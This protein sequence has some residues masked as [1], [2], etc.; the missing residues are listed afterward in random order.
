M[1]NL[2]PRTEFSDNVFTRDR[3]AWWGRMDVPG[4]NVVTDERMT[5]KTA[6]QRFLP[7]EIEKVELGYQ[8][9]E[10]V[11]NGETISTFEGTP[12]RG[13]Q[14]TDTQ[15]VLGVATD[16]YTVASN[17]EQA[18]VLEEAVQG[19]DYAVASI[20]ALAH[21]RTTFIAVDFADAPDANASGQKIYPFLSVVNGNDG[22]GSLKLYATGIRPECYNTIDMGWM[23]GVKF[24]ALRHTA[25][26]SDRV[27]M[28]QNDIR[29]YL[30]LPAKAEVMVREL[31]RHI[32]SAEAY[33]AAL[34]H[35]TPIPEPKVKDGKTTNQREITNASNRRDAILDLA[36]NDERVG[37]QGTAWGAFQ[38]FSTYD[39]W[40][41]QVRM[42]KGSGI[43][44]RQQ[45]TLDKT[46]SGEL[47]KNDGGRMALV[48]NALGVTTVKV[49][50][51][52]LVLA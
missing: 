39:Q 44:V 9:T 49:A 6:V 51:S 31:T 25:S 41:R 17:A 4:V 8:V 2:I 33:R 16:A 11:G 27:K 29:T 36:F 13:L 45:T 32:V 38:A 40:E 35:L 5:V 18:E 26:I 34:E 3:A 22:S 50:K 1:S 10:E 42:T 43:T 21:G 28:I 52:G 7:W 48:L 15:R 19:M 24:G 37:Y 20:G 47:A 23:T 12:F 46:F 30:A 14:R